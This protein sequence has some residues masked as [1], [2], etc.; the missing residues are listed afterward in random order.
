MKKIIFLT[1]IFSV[2]FFSFAAHSQN[3]SYQAPKADFIVAKINN[4]AITYSELTDRYR[5]V[6]SASKISIKDIQDQK[7]LMSQILDKMIDEE[8]IRQEA[9]NLKITV[10]INEITESV[11]ILAAQQKKNAAQFKFFFHNKGLSFDNYLKQVESEILW[12]KIISD[13]LRSKVKITEVEVKEF[14]EQHKFGTDVKKFL[15]AEVLISPIGN[16]SQK[17]A[18][19]ANKLAAELKQGA[20]FR[21]I[22]RQFSN[23]IHNDNSGEIG[24]VSQTDIDAKIYTAISKLG[25]GEYSEPVSLADGYHIFKLL[26]VKIEAKIADQDLNAARNAIFATKLQVLAK[27]YLMDLRKR[28]FVEITGQNQ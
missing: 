27:G 8:L 2:N 19:L 16:S 3:K 26:D 6:V 23:G 9:A 5:F 11:E 15:I 17:A 7:L 28:A 10:T 20:D 4:K 13:T 14:F 24:W 21:N 1:I 18:Q 25:K 12:S 22:V